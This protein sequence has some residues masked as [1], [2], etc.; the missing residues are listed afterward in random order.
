VVATRSGL[1][2][3]QPEQRTFA[4][5]FSGIAADQLKDDTVPEAVVE[6]VGD[7]KERAK[8]QGV[9]VQPLGDGRWRAGFQIAP[10]KDGGKLSDVGPIELRVCLKHGDN[11][12]TETWA[13]RVIP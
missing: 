11:Y 13:N 5:E 3:W 7:G 9:A 12:L 8:I 10:V 2:D 4:V 6:I 1:H